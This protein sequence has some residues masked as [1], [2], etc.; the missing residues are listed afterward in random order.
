MDEHWGN[1]AGR[2]FMFL[3]MTTR[4]P[5]HSAPLRKV[6]SEYLGLGQDSTAGYISAMASVLKLP[7]E[8]EL[9]VDDLE[10]PPLPRLILLRPVGLVREEL[11]TAL[12]GANPVSWAR[13]VFDSGVRN[14]LEACSHILN[15]NTG[16]GTPDDDQL[17]NIRSLVEAVIDEVARDGE[18]DRESREALLRY[19]Y[20]LQRALDL[21][22]VSGPQALIDELD[23]FMSASRRLATSP[24]PA[25][26][27][28]LQKLTGAIVVAVGLFTGPADVH[29]AI[30]AYST[31]WALPSS[32]E[33]PAGAGVDLPLS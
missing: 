14:D 32:V 30:T 17:T 18:L 3:E 16:L 21:H 6:W 22:R 12:M 1:P 8:I 28:R 24:A 23:R 29:S 13:S 31:M 10:S 25:L 15:A 4:Y 33:A 11:A 20:T 9:A 26:R 5:D 2:L 7:D 19:A 27:D